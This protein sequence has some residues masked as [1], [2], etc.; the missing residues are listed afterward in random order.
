MYHRLF[1]TTL[2]VFLLSSR[3]LCAQDAAPLANANSLLQHGKWDEAR[4]A[5]ENLAKEPKYQAAANIGLAQSY[6]MV[7]DYEKA[8]TLLATVRKT[9]D[10]LDLAAAEGDLQ[11]MLGR[12]SEAQK[13]AEEILAKDKNHFQARWI[14]ARIARD[15]GKLDLAEKDVRWFVREYTKA[16][17]EDKDITDTDKLLIVGQAATENA[18]WKG[19]SD[20]FRFILNEL[21]ADILKIN[22]DVWEAEYQAGILLLEK[23][24]RPEAMEAFDKALKINPQCAEAQ[25][26]RGMVFLQ[27]YELKDAEEAVEKALN[28]NSRLPSACCL[29]ADI[30]MMSDDYATATKFLEKA[31]ATNPKY[32]LALGRLAACYYLLNQTEKVNALAK[33]VESFTSKPVNFYYQLAHA[34][35]ERK[36]FKPAEEYY[37]KAIT[38]GEQFPQPRAGLAMLELRLGQ[39]TEARD[40]LNKSFEADRFNVRVS[41]MLKVLKHLDKYDTLQTKHYTIRFDSKTDKILADFIADYLEDTHTKLAIEFGYEPKERIL[42]EL[43][44]SHEMFSGR[45]IGLPDLHT[46]GACTGNVVTIASPRARGLLKPFNWG[47]VIRH[48]LVHAFNLNQ[49]DYKVP[50]WLTEG[51]AVRNENP[52]RPY[53][54]SRELRRA[55]EANELMNLDS[56]TLGFVRPRSQDEWM[57]AYCQSNLYVEYVREKFGP[58]K[59]GEMLSAYREGLDTTA[60]IRK[61]C[62]VGKA[63]FEAGYRVYL[64]KIVADIP[65]LM[66]KVE[67]EMSIEQLEEARDKSPED[68]NVAAKL[69]E[70]YQKKERPADARKLVEIVLKKKADH[71][72][73]LL[74]KSRLL[75]ASGDSAAAKSLLEIAQKDNPKDVGILLALIKA[76]RDGDDTSKAIVLLEKARKEAPLDGNWLE[77]LSQIYSM[78]MELDKL[79][80]VLQ[81][82]VLYESEDLEAR[83]QLARVYLTGKKYADAEKAAKEALRIDVLNAEAQRIVLTALREQ[84]K[85][86]EA[87]VLEKRFGPPPAEKDQN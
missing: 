73:A 65:P 13:T 51:L 44:N 54:W 7:G 49:T 37:R 30:L 34:L 41:N 81:E 57:L 12:W 10:S 2:G 26:G 6:R 28:I 47:R 31:V 1:F 58:Q 62:G 66:T 56:I 69:A 84:E 3:L 74:V 8:L 21:Y 33:Q 76:Y 22:P 72:I 85:D 9:I 79:A 29:K 64:K 15:S 16:S 46:I 38:Y 32:E 11:Y 48:E 55:F 71:P 61:V 36:S 18:R 82:R 39:E 53:T 20:Q 75:E 70:Q 4:K 40:L 35:E 87:K 42:V 14:Q 25:V 83:I 86:I 45:T 19:L 80:D 77:Q 60:V 67:P 63:E 43:F 17:N 5:F 24:N 59:I 78:R 50:H 27:Q 68:L 52:V 23:Y